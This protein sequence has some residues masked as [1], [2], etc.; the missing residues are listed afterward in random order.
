M[1][2]F[3]LLLPYRNRDML[4]L[5]RCL[6]S[7]SAQDFNDF[8]L[9]LVDYGTEKK[10]AAEVAALCANYNFVRLIYNDFE[11]HLWN[12]SHALNT[13]LNATEAVYIITL[14]VDMIYCPH[15][16]TA[17]KA[18]AQPNLLLFYGCY[19]LPQNFQA[20]STLHTQT[21][22]DL[23]ESDA[24][25]LGI[26]V[27][28][29][30]AMQEVGGFDEYFRVWGVEDLDMR[31]RLVAYGLKNERLQTK[32]APVF[33]QWHAA[34]DVRSNMPADWKQKMLDYYHAKTFPKDLKN[35]KANWGRLLATNGRPAL[36]LKN[37]APN[38][39]FE[40][41]LEYALLGWVKRFMLLNSGDFLI[42]KQSTQLFETKQSRLGPYMAAANRILAKIKIS[43]R[44]TDLETNRRGQALTFYELR[45]ALFY[46]LYYFEN[47]IADYYWEQGEEFLHLV[48]VKN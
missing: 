27:A 33:H 36:C 25:A 38:Y 42:L 39:T 28:P 2:L 44:L 22:K 5:K 3:S 14:D 47:E 4:R 35:P 34:S 30:A 18:R 7:L 8:E 24:A 41:P 9:V 15:F 46:F 32:D 31:T 19:Y 6:E 16:L 11:G 40:F 1:P 23:P 43:Y 26:F 45:D 21:P 10:L 48:V 20:Y 37:E 12:R 13:A 29:R 17:V